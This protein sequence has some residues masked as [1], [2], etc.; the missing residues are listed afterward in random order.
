MNDSSEFARGGAR[1]SDRHRAKGA[2]PQMTRIRPTSTSG[3][4]PRQAAQ[5][6]RE[7]SKI[8]DPVVKRRRRRRTLAVVGFVVAVL[9]LAGAGAAYAWYQTLNTNLHQVTG[10]FAGMSAGVAT[11]PAPGKPF[12]MLIMGV[13]TRPTD[14]TTARSDTLIVAYVDAAR[15]RIT[16]MSIPRDTKVVI[17]GRGTAK[18]NEAMQLGGPKLVLRTVRSFTGLPISHWAYIDFS[19]FKDIVDA[20]GGIDINVP[21]T[22]NDIEASNNHPSA[23]LIKKGPRH[24][25]G[26]HA[27]TFVRA[28]HQFADQ[29]FTRMKD[30]QLFMKALGKKILSANVLSLPALANS[31]SKNVHTDLS[32]SQ[33]IGLALNFRGMNDKM[34]QSVTMPGSPQY[35]GGVSYVVADE[36]GLAEITAKMERGELFT[37]VASSVAT[38]VT[39]TVTTGAA[40]P[41]PSTITV[42]VRNGA[43]VSGIA[44]S[45]ANALTKKGFIVKDTGNMGQFV[46][47]K[48]MVVF[49]SSANA[50]KANVVSN[51]L[52]ISTVEPSKGLYTFSGEVLV[53]IGKDF[54]PATFGIST[55]KRN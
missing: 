36:A 15:K 4:T 13:D 33:I 18:I 29:D 55:S 17:A 11:A 35:V 31:A 7:A 41:R 46:F 42:T 48:S 39:K 37:A 6:R 30:Q 24:L 9:V 8:V 28:R 20:V 54:D 1:R 19:G 47:D 22:I 34:F 53:V 51:A 32:I 38:T 25:D 5:R 3:E 43:G 10:Q 49:A 2:S 23:A 44:K 12:Y 27:L 40:A 45:V 16:T 21:Y 52:N 50:D 26:Q 14:F